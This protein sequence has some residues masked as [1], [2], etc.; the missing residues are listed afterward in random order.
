MRG[1]G[2]RSEWPRKMQVIV[3]HLHGETVALRAGGERRERRGNEE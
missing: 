1:D 2:S 3:A